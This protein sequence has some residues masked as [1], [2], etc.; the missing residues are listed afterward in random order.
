MQSIQH[1]FIATLPVVILGALAM[2]IL[3]LL[4]LISPDSGYQA[5]RH[6][7]DTIQQSFYGLMS[8]TLVL[9]ISH[10]LASHY[11]QTDQLNFDP[12]I[13][14]ILSMLTLI[15]MVHQD[16]GKE[17][18]E[19]LGVM[20]VAKGLFCSIIFTELYVCISR[21]RLLNLSYL[22]ENVETSLQTA[23]A[24]VWPAVLA[25]IIVLSLYGFV[26]ETATQLSYWF[27]MF[28]GEVDPEKGLTLWQTI[29]LLLVNQLSWF[30][31]IH[32]SS[33]IEMH[34]DTIFLN[35]SSHVYSRQYLNMFVHI[36][37]AGCTFGLVLALFFSRIRSSR[38]LGRYALLPSIFNI[39]ELL[40]FGLPIIFN[41]F[42]IFPFIFIPVIAAC[43]SRL[44]LE[45]DWMQWSGQAET[46]STPIFLGGYLVTGQWQGI[47]L[48]AV[49]IFISFSI[50]RPFL[51]AY[52]NN[53]DKENNKKQLQMLKALNHELDLESVYKSKTEMG[54]FSRML[55]NDFRE[56]ISND[57]LNLYYQPKVNS[58]GRVV[59]AEA[60]LRWNHPRF[61]FINPALIVELSELDGSI[62]DLGYWVITRCLSD[63]LA[64]N[65]AGLKDLKI[66]LN[67]S[68][69]QFER[70]DFFDKV[71]IL[72]DRTNIPP[73]SLELEI[74]EGNKIN[75]DERV[76]IGLQKLSNHGFHIAVDD[77]GMGYTS[78]RYLKS[79]PVNTLKIDGS[80]VK[81]VNNSKI[82]KEIIG[83]MGQLA[84]SMDVT[85]VAEWV[86]NDAQMY[87]LGE[88]GCNE[89]QGYL[90]SP[91]ISLQD[92][93]H[94][95]GVTGVQVSKD[96]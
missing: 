37:G 32:G 84:T 92:F 95:C 59:G 62:H 52:E 93:T 12:L 64:L 38:Q 96:T 24:S 33:I 2:T 85:L 81:D 1:G 60:L 19:Q 31:G 20:A 30:I 80:I 94:Y 53:R 74:T 39:N 16:Y 75:L 88:L 77:F 23:I 4:A 34:A 65:K 43:L 90:F 18:F 83:S 3:Q 45:L 68:P 73:S 61:G 14:S 21:H 35:D 89:F 57:A 9:S 82:V 40:I 42:L 55:L 10:R 72:I 76:L 27:P 63:K 7:C 6:I 22:K 69:C 91:A 8:L 41:R 70:D 47:A 36:G 79:F 78:L 48:Q 66:A 44:A 5:I 86:E 28:I 26:A 11:Q 46:W 51:L 17:I 87:S 56:A 13:L 25:S 29:K 15:G 71:I 67:V 54:R 49:L 50:Y 58:A